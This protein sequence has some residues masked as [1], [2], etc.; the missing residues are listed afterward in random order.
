ME[1]HAVSLPPTLEE[2]QRKFNGWRKTRKRRGPI[3]PR[4]W[5][6]AVI[7]AGRYSTHKI[8]ITL[9]LNYTQLQKRI[10]LAG[11]APSRPPPR[12][13]HAMPFGNFVEYTVSTPHKPECLIEMENR[14]GDKMRIFVSVDKSLDLL[15][16]GH[17]FWVRKP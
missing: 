11:A 15:S 8:S 13:P 9:R 6:A 17:S 5:D 1:Q 14:H 10:S 12:R 3:P 16:L 4:L 7:L 2:V